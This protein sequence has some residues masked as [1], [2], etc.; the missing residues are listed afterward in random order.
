VLILKQYRH[1]SARSAL[2][3]ANYALHVGFLGVRFGDLRKD[4]NNA[5]VNSIPLTDR[6]KSKITNLLLA[7]D[8]TDPGGKIIGDELR[9]MR[10]LGRK[11]EIESLYPIA[12]EIEIDEG[13]EVETFGE[14]VVGKIVRGEYS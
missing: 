3:S 14:L 1:G 13:H 10:E 2:E 12:D 11:A 5:L 6:D 4:A 7:N 8:E 9:K